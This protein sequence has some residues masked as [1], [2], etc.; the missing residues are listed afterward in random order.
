M[1]WRS[2]KQDII[3]I[4]EVVQDEND[5]FDIAIIALE[6]LETLLLAQR[7]YDG[8]LESTA[9]GSERDLHQKQRTLH[10]AF[11]ELLLQCHALNNCSAYDEK[12]IFH[13]A[14]ELFMGNLMEWYAGRKN[15]QFFDEVDSAV[16]PLL[17]SLIDSDP[18][19]ITEIFNDCVYDTTVKKEESLDEKHNKVKSGFD[20]WIKAQ[21]YFAELQAQKVE[22][23]Q[24]AVITSH[25]RGEAV[26]GYRRIIEAL[27]STQSKSAPAKLVYRL[28]AQYLPDVV[29]SVPHLNE[30]YIEGYYE[31]KE[32]YSSIEEKIEVDIDKFEKDGVTYLRLHCQNPVD[33]L[34][35]KVNSPHILWKHGDDDCNG[36]IYL[37][38]NGMLYC[39]KC[40]QY[41]SLLHVSF[42]ENNRIRFNTEN[43]IAHSDKDLI[44][45]LVISGSMANLGGLDWLEKV[46]VAIRESPKKIEP[47]KEEILPILQDAVKRI[48]DDKNIEYN[49]IIID[50]K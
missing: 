44:K 20:A 19:K 2:K 7:G 16:I 35:E 26:D 31:K 32:L 9:M 1:F 45:A 25:K 38:D 12:E 36:N 18:E 48:L 4:T 5:V 15:L 49:E 14:A 11:E 29:E 3:Q 22:L 43:K 24:K 27:T 28:V 42:A 41:K 17:F 39:R 6:R 46:I 40:S 21:E 8:S 37:G 34:K 30:E 23:N 50:I 33:I 10:G 47:N 13:I